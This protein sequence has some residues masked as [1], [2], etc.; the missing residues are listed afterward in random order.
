M[1]GSEAA[2]MLLVRHA[3]LRAQCATHDAYQ[4]ASTYVL[5]AFSD[6]PEDELV[7]KLV[8]RIEATLPA[9]RR[10]VANVRA[11]VAENVAVAEPNNL[12]QS[13]KELYFF[14]WDVRTAAIAARTTNE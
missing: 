9:G 3:L 5:Y 4:E 2:A 12:A 11:G 7:E 10:E 8:A 6:T 13:E 1:I 14:S